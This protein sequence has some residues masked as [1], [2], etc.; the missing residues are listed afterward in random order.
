M[1]SNTDPSNF[2]NEMLLTGNIRFY[3]NRLLLMGRPGV[4]I[5]MGILSSIIA[6]LI[7]YNPE[8]AYNAGSM[9]T[10]HLFEDYNKRFN[11]EPTKVLQIT[12]NIVTSSGLGKFNFDFDK[13]IIISSLN[14]APLAE[15][16]IEQLGKSEKP[17]CFF[18]AGALNALLEKVFNKTYSTKEVSC[19][20]KGDIE[21]KF[22]STVY[23]RKT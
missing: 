9:S 6:K 18:I 2:L 10:S 15:A 7:N 20:A 23:E 3:D 13:D 12:S 1:L 22:V 21:C 11:G 19:K 14:P 4:L 17:V 8:D 16:Y 5:N